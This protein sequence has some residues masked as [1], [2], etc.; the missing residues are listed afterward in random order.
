[1]V[2][3]HTTAPSLNEWEWIAS[4]AVAAIAYF[5]LMDLPENRESM[6][7]FKLSTYS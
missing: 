1:M 3:W 6:L 5:T 7:T 2:E 4:S